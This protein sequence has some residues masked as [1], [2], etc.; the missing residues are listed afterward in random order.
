MN[1]IENAKI[2]CIKLN[3][4]FYLLLEENGVHVL[5]KTTD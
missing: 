5:E 2:T 3:T 1:T 4:I